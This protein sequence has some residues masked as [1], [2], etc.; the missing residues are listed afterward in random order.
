MKKVFNKEYLLERIKDKDIKIK[1]W[2]YECDGR[3]VDAHN[4]IGVWRIHD[5]WCD[6]IDD[7]GDKY[8]LIKLENEEL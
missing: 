6:F 8:R 2:I 4:Q 1:D 7:N 5:S 3:E